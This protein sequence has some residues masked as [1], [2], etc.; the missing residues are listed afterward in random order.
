IVF[1]VFSTN[2]VVPKLFNPIVGEIKLI[3][4]WN[5]TTVSIL[6]LASIVLGL[7]IYLIGNIKNFRSEDSFVGGGETMREDSGMATTDFY[8]T[9]RN[10]GFLSTLYEKAEKRW[11]D[12]YDISKKIILWFSRGLQGAHTGV[13]PNYAIWIFAGLIIML[14]ILL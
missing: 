8:E 6:V 1:G 5:S 13:L 14:L 12:I 2:L 7:I 10:F 11:F 4:M 3:G 9:I